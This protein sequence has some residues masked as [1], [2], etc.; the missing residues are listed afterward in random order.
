MK[1]P[2][3]PIVM[4]VVVFFI[5]LFEPLA[6]ET[7]INDNPTKG[8]RGVLGNIFLLLSTILFWAWFWKKFIR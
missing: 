3:A 4:I 6:T 5:W 2:F 1:S 7:L 8:I